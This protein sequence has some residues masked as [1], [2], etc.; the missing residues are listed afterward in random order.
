VNIRN[1]DLRKM[2]DVHASEYVTQRQQ[3]L[4]LPSMIRIDQRMDDVLRRR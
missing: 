3:D 2:M 4:S 1:F